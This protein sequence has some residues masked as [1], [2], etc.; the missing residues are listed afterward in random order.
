VNEA[1]ILHLLK[2]EQ[3]RFAAQALRQPA[4]R[5]AFEY[6]HRVGFYAGLE[7]AVTV[8]LKALETENAKEF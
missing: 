7:Q 1:Y 8:V 5:D 2:E 3:S 6:G 4:Q